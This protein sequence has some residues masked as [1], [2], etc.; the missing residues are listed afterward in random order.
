M[1]SPLNTLLVLLSLSIGG[2]AQTL[3][4]D[5]CACSP[6]TYEITFDFSLSCPPTNVTRGDGIEDIA[7]LISAFGSPSTTD[8]VPVSVESIDI[9]EGGVNLEVIHQDEV[10]GPFVNGDTFTYT[11]KFIEGAMDVPKGI[12]FNTHALNQAGENILNVLNIVYTQDCNIYPV[13]DAN[14]SAGWF[15][16]V[17]ERGDIFDLELLPGTL[18]CSLFSLK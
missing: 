16:F 2:S 5:V 6:G 3:G 1:N 15:L 8:L 14:Q 12:Q 13:I 17:S 4:Q 11:T 7:C 18:T 9:L 10:M